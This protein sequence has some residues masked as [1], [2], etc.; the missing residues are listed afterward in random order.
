MT[1]SQRTRLSERADSDPAEQGGQEPGRGADSIR[2]G[3]S[4]LGVPAR[5]L[6][7]GD[8]R[9]EVMHKGERSGGVSGCFARMAANL[10]L[11]F[12]RQK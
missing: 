5:H 11:T 7:G 8:P 4:G 2:R 6:C 9:N 3:S 12:G 1:W 10:V